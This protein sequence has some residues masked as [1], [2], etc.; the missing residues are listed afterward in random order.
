MGNNNLFTRLSTTTKWK[1]YWYY[2]FI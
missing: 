2:A 1:Y